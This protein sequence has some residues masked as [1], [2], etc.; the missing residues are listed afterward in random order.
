MGAQAPKDS[1]NLISAF[2]AAVGLCLQGVEGEGDLSCN[3][4]FV[5]K[6][7]KLLKVKLV[8]FGKGWELENEQ[9]AK[10]EREG[11]RTR[12]GNLVLHGVLG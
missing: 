10:R 2:V 5:D 3:I 8:D 11:K 1:A 7:D 4:V 6:R 12:K 9:G